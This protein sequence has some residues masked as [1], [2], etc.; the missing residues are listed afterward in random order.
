MKACS[1]ARCADAVGLRWFDFRVWNFAF[2]CHGYFDAAWQSRVLVWRLSTALLS[3]YNR[4]IL[5]RFRPS[6]C[7]LHI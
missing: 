6:L 1:T 2:A 5:I 7:R 4:K 3:F